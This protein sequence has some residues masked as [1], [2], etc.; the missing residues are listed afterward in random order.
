MVEVNQTTNDKYVVYNVKEIG[1]YAYKLICLRDKGHYPTIERKIYVFIL[2][3]YDQ[4]N[5]TFLDG[6]RKVTILLQLKHMLANLKQV[7]NRT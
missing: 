2:Y 7:R 3:Y 5:P 1:V 4:N 6:I